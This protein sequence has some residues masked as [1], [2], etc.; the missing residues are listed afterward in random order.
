MIDS[1]RLRPTARPDVSVLIVNFNSTGLLKECLDFLAAS[2]IASRL[3]TIVV[4]NAS[5]DFD[6]AEFSKPYPW[7]RWL[8]QSTNTTCTGG[9]NIAFHHATGDFLLMLNPDTRVERKAVERALHHLQDNDELAAVGAYFIGPD[10]EIQ[11]NYRRLPALADLPVL[12]FER[13]F[14]NTRRGRRFLMAD[15]VFAGPTPV[16]H[17]AGAFL[18]IR[19]EAVAGELLDSTYFNLLSDV[20]LSRRLKAAGRIGVFPDVRCHHQGGGGGM[21]TMDPRLRLRLHQDFTWGLR[22]YFAG[23]GTVGWLTLNLGLCLYWMSRIA[24]VSLK[25]PR[26]FPHAVAV[27]MRALGGLAPKYD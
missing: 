22:Q 23:R 3:E 10:G 24:H 18:L 4:D 21:N 13:L 14:R 7:V 9:N 19:R 8:P 1:T 6:L 17:C 27:A 2:T 5:D 15:E 25:S 26:T 20:D 11:R 12:L 16:E